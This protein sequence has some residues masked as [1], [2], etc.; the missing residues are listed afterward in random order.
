MFEATKLGRSVTKQ[1]FKAQQEAL[2]TQLL[3]VQRELT[4]TNMPV[5]ILLAGLEG[6]GKGGVTN[7]LNQWLDTRGV[8]TFAFWDETDEERARPRYWRFWRSLPER[9]QLAI[10]FGG[11]YQMPIEH[12][13]RGLCTDAELDAE[14]NRIVDF[15]RMLTQDGALIVKF[16]FHMSEADQ[17]ARLKA[18]SRDDRSRWKMLPDKSKFS[19]HYQEFEHVA[20]RVILHTDRG[21]S[22]W[23]LIEA[24]DRRYR[25]LTVGKT[26]LQAIKARLSHPEPE[27]PPSASKGL[28]LPD[29]ETAQVTLIDQLDLTQRLGRDEYKKALHSLQDELNELAWQAY[30][31]K[32][33]TVMVFEGVD[34]AGKGGAI[35]RITGA[36][37]ARLYRALPIAAPTDEE[38]A[39]HY[40]WR[41]WRHIPRAGY[42]TIYDRSWYGRVLVE[43]VEDGLASN[44]EWRRAY[45]EISRFEEQLVESGIILFKFWLQISQEEQLRRFEERE[46]VAYKRYKITAE[47]WR[48]RE[49]WP[50]YKAAANEMIARTSTETAPWSLIEAEDKRFARIK[51]LRIL[52]D[53]LKDALQ[54]GI[55]VNHLSCSDK[56]TEPPQA[57]K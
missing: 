33:S 9:G 25:D 12:R 3:A 46:Q 19:E 41:F 6:A 28:D 35:G 29:V 16:W 24:T 1:D 27:D 50:A 34:A 36:I 8:Q 30:K 13:F 52:C 15:E 51:V 40:L 45:S 2:R 14:L 37:D 22:P 18:L 31:A 10:L 54:R 44:A 17:K 55:S 57:Q 7:R 43:R 26:L 11:W 39:H 21:I 20:E 49:K 47:D 48:N 32:R 4:Q 42:L 38:I 5:V 23:Y 56:G 53:G